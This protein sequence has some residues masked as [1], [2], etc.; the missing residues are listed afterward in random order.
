MSY[1][2]TQIES[3]GNGTATDVQGK[4]L[5]FVGNLP[6]KAGDTVWTDSK[7]IFGNSTPK[8]APL[9]DDM[10]AGIPVVADKI[11]DD[12]E[13]KS[14]YLLPNGNFRK[15]KLAADEWIV[16]DEKNYEHGDE[17]NIIDA[18]ID[19]NGDIWTVKDGFYR[20]K[21]VPI[22][23][24][25][26]Y[27]QGF[28]APKDADLEKRAEESDTTFQICSKTTPYFGELFNFDFVSFADIPAEDT[29]IIFYKNGAEQFKV[30]LKQFADLVEELALEAGSRIM[31]KSDKEEG[32]VNWTMQPAPPDSDIALSYASVASLTIDKEGNYDAIISAGA[33]GLC[34]PYLTF[35]GSLF[36]RAFPND[37]DKTFSE[38][39]IECLGTIDDILFE[40]KSLP[41]VPD[42]SKY[43]PFAGA[44]KDDDG[45][46]T[47][48]YKN[49]LAGKANYY[50]PYYRT[51]DSDEDLSFIN[52]FE[53]VLFESPDL[54]YKVNFEQFAE[55]EGDEKDENDEYTP[56]FKQ[57]ILDKAE[58]YIP[59]V[60]FKYYYWFPIVFS[61]CELL[62]VHN[63]EV[64]GTIYEYKGGGNV[65]YSPGDWDETGDKDGA[66]DPYNDFVYNDD[67][68]SPQEI[69]FPIGDFKY[70]C[71]DFF[72]KEIF[73]GENNITVP[74]ELYKTLADSLK[75][76]S[77]YGK[78]EGYYYSF[79]D[80]TAVSI[81]AQYDFSAD[82]LIGRQIFKPALTYDFS[83]L[84]DS[85]YYP[86]PRKINYPCMSGWF[87]NP[88]EDNDDVNISYSFVQFKKNKFA[89]GLRGG[90][91]Y[92]FKADG[93]YSKVAEGLK[94]FRLR[95]LKNI[96]KAR[97]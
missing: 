76:Y 16:N 60:R 1:Y 23:H 32:A 8:P 40:D 21:S 68:F 50:A 66:G 35:N 80:S 27:T 54:H 86:N 47:P 22:V 67:D 41:L 6:C 62:K 29:D 44:E 30:N 39:L 75:C 70:H 12:E 91:L 88:N 74:E 78:F 73:D 81:A 28:Y 14:G 79:I 95:E 46:Y 36:D 53:A 57:Y 3:V 72:V 48:E 26:L 65:V 93:D 92:T 63:G 7:V 77:A 69:E 37:E 55:F 11:K 90:D 49:Y 51:A 34:Y 82:N 83:D 85:I 19:D 97:K 56:E 94:N 96:A 87:K 17:E 18:E 24:N 42:F 2:P 52:S 61:A 89:L 15:R 25:H 71:E 64:T 43:Q 59:K 45:N 31:E 84:D 58:Y 38:T 9:L 4:K 33:M 10:R 5:R 20:Y 13:K